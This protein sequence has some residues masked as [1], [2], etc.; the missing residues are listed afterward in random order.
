MTQAH[1]TRP[2]ASY[3]ADAEARCPTAHDLA[4]HLL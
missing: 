2:D 3:P 4:R 1:L